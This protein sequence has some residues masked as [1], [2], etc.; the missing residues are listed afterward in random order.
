MTRILTNTLRY[1]GS[2]IKCKK[3]ML[4]IAKN[5]TAKSIQKFRYSVIDL[6]TM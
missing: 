5:T 1:I 4:S 3:V 6:A 2:A